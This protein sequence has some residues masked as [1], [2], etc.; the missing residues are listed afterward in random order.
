MNYT[1]SGKILKE[2]KKANKI[3][4]NCHKSPDPDSVGS[5][6]ATY[7]VLKQ[8]GKDAT[9]ISPNEVGEEYNFLKNWG[10]IKKVNFKNFDYKDFDLFI[11]LDSSNWRMVTGLS[12]LK[13]FDVPIVVIDHHKTHDSYGKINLVDDGVGSC[14][15]ILYQIFNDW[16]VELDKDIATDLLTGIL[17]DTGVFRYPGVT[18]RTFDIAQKLMALGADK[19]EIVYKVFGSLDFNLLKFWG[20]ILN[21]FE[22]DET[23]SF[24]WAAIPYDIFKKYDKP[25]SGKETAASLFTQ[26]VNKTD[27]GFIAVEERKGTLSISFRSRTG[28][29]VSALAEKLGGGGHRAASGAKIEGLGFDD[30]IEKVLAI[31]RKYANK[32]S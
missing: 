23:H 19:E 27:F 3:L 28:F 2:I 9:I 10:K 25:L 12:G 4:V 14:A 15:E 29:D 6:I 24:V 26:V 30:A 22:K 8:I 13:P 21:K 11:A 5:A 31:C 16:K 18:S 20:E 17:G 32:K 1:K 7:L